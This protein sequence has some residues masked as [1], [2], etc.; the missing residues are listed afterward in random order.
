MTA[1]TAALADDG[2]AT[3]PGADRAASSVAGP[4]SDAR[5]EKVPMT[6]G[7]G[8]LTLKPDTSLLTAP[9]TTYPVYI[10]PATN[11]VTSTAGHYDEVYSNSACSD[12][13][14]YDKPQ[15]NGEGVGYQGYG[16]VCGNGIER[17][18][19]AIDTGKLSPDMVVSKAEI[20]I[21]TTYAASWDCSHNQP[22]TL[23]TTDPIS[24]STDWNSRPGTHD[25]TY[26]PVTTHVASG[27]NPNSSCSNHT[28]AFDV[29]DQAQ[30]IA[31]KGNDVWTIGLYGDESSS[32]PDD[33]LRMSTTFALTVTFDIAPD[34]PTNLHTTP[35][36]VGADADCTTAGVGWIGAT[37][38]S[39]AGSNIHLD[40]TVTS[41]VSGENVSG[42]FFVWDRTNLDSSGNAATMSSPSS[43]YLASGTTADVPIG[44]TLK[45]GHEYGWDV[46]A[47]TN[48]SQHLTS[49]K[50]AHCWFDTDFTPPA[51]PG[52]A[53]NA[54]FPRVGE[55]SPAQPVYAGP[56]VTSAFTV[57]A[58]DVAPDDTCNP[59][60][61][62]SSGVDHFLWSLDSQPTAAT[63]TSTKVAST[64]G[65]VATA[66]LPVPVTR[67][68]VHTLYVAAVDKAGNISQ[69]PASYTFTAPW[70]PNTKVAQG[71][72]SGDGVPD[73]LATTSTGDLEMIPGDTDPAQAP[74]PAQSGPI[75]GSDPVPAVTGPVIVSTAAGAPTGSWKDYLVAHRGNL[76]GAD[77][78]DLFAYNTK[79]QQLYIVKNDYDPADD[80]AF[81]PVK[82]SNYAGYVGRRYDVVTKDACESADL[83][84]D[85]SRCRTAGYDSQTWNVSQLVTPGNVF[86]NTSNYP[87]VITM[88]NKRLWIY[89]ADGG[90]HLKNPLL[91]GDGDWSGLT[92]I[93]PGTVGG[94]PTLWAR[95]NASGTLYTFPL[96]LDGNGLPPL[97]HA[98][99]RT[100]LTSALTVSGGGRLCLDDSGSRT[101]NHNKIQVYT[102][103]GTS[104]QQW[105][106]L[107][108]GSLRVLGRCL[109]VTSSGVDNGTLVQLFTCNGTGAQK[110]TP[111]ANGSLVNPESGKCLDD[112]SSSTTNGTQV[113]IYT[114]NGTAAQNWTG[115]AAAGWNAHPGTALAPV[116]SA[117]DDPAVASP[118]DIN[119]SDGGPDGNPDLYAV[120]SG[121]Q[122]T[123]YPGAAPASGTAAFGTAVSLGAAVNSSA[124]WWNLD[125]GTGATATDQAAGL[126]ASL[127]GSYSWATDSSRGKVLSLDGT[128]G[129]GATSGPAVNTTGSF[130]VSAWVKLNSLT[131]NSTFVSQ[132]DDPSVGAANGFQL[133]YSSN[134]QAWAF[135]RHNADD[136]SNSFT[137]AYGSKP[138]TGKWTHLVGVFDADAGTLSLYV[139]GS[140][141]ATKDYAGTS[142]NATGPVQIGRRLY[143]NS[144]AEYANAQ[145]SDVR[146]WDNALPAADAAAPGDNPRVSGLS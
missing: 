146:I 37:T 39:D 2:T 21:K 13:P 29:T 121:G 95:D 56:G 51:T 144:Y 109:D 133:Y 124:H 47:K 112:P 138:V 68:G 36:A 92:L 82:Y 48:S 107:A 67:W 131:A 5:V 9:G 52:I 103:N 55:G 74:A 57:T 40:A 123:E 99:V 20:D 126:N 136:P 139:N 1:R 71:D 120:D 89:Q 46:Y 34:V 69:S 4:G 72:I 54:S 16:G 60:A 22:I 3:P 58:Q 49:D 110:W 8:G 12:S 32:S 118:G 42:E 76:H 97:L 116:L 30:T 106:Y 100:A 115:A 93:A 130:T 125:E 45:D 11:P 105:S 143:Q 66:S 132:S 90:G 73:L 129:Y 128:T 50:S 91:L 59:G 135:N 113:Q 15:T 41:N 111:G 61:C 98:P 18:Y 80:S 122:L 63:G 117:A 14:Q 142:W 145:I 134:A 108:D 96:T 23:H 140:L 137:A 33:Y 27:A 75:T 78:D 64:S 24:S 25:T 119:S 94:T 85:D 65:G 77:V 53:D 84:A 79:T 19:Y 6:A 35:K 44:F 104:A 7:R 31:D 87:A 43:G 70:N 88:E 81:P 102:C 28:A 38:Y 26:P 114:C 101:T 62:L 86:G 141:S 83:V 127:T 17:S 10:D